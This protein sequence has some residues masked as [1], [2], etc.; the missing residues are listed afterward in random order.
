MAEAFE[1]DSS[2]YAHVLRAHKKDAAGVQSLT[3]SDYLRGNTP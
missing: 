1:G 3:Y 2:C